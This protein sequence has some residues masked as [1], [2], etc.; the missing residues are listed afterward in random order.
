MALKE[1]IANTIRLFNIMDSTRKTQFINVGTI[2]KY[3]R[4]KHII[5]QNRIIH[6]V[7]S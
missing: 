7:L 1:D 6:L 5:S 4:G 3:K 2:V